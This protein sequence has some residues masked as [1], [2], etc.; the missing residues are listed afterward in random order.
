M[1]KHLLFAAILC[2]GFLTAGATT[3]TVQVANFQF[4]VPGGSSTVNAS[5]GDTITWVWVSGSH[6]TTCDPASPQ[7]SGNSLPAGAATW[8]SPIN[9]TNKTFS[10]KLTV[11]GVY[12]YWCIPHAPDMAGT[13]NVSAVLPVTLLSF[14]ASLSQDGKALLKWTVA[15]EQNVSYYSIQKSIDGSH[16]ADIGKVTATGVSSSQ[17]T[18]TYADNAASN[19]HYVYYTIKTVDNDGRTQLSPIALL[20]NDKVKGGIIISMSPNPVS[21]PGHLMLQFNADKDGSMLVQLFDSNGKIVKQTNM[22]ATAGINNGHFHLGELPSG[23]Y[24]VVFTLDGKRE[25]KRLVFE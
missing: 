16:F 3:Y 9:S 23:T 7:G 12:K 11:A 6:T 17:K 1:N 19:S 24:T 4:S 2:A 8:N 22:M 5:V 14:G 25:T 18:Y 15:N 13:I 21:S 20:K 10:Y